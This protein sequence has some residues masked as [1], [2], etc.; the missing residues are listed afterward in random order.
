M[1]RK[2]KMKARLHAGVVDA[3]ALQSGDRRPVAARPRGRGAPGASR[4]FARIVAALQTQ[5]VPSVR[6]D[7]LHDLRRP[8]PLTSP[9]PTTV[10]RRKS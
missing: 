2:Q 3:P 10:K 5:Q 1:S 7:S 9:T 8:V 4:L 6:P